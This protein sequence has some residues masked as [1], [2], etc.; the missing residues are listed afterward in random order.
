[1]AMTQTIE[2]AF[3]INFVEIMVVSAQESIEAG[4]VDLAIVRVVDQPLEFVCVVVYSV[5]GLLECTLGF[6]GVGE[7][8]R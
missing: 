5:L 3:E 1:M 4:R 8:C 2:Y 6:Y 7:F